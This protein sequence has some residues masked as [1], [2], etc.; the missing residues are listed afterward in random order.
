MVCMCVYAFRY[1]AD[2]SSSMTHWDPKKSWE[3]QKRRRAV[4][5]AAANRMN[6]HGLQA[7]PRL[8]VPSLSSSSSSLSPEEQQRRVRAES[9]EYI[10]CPPP[11]PDAEDAYDDVDLASGDHR[12]AIAELACTK[13]TPPSS[14]G[15]SSKPEGGSASVSS[16]R[17]VISQVEVDRRRKCAIQ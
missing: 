13:S 10:E 17:S 12:G 14:V 9:M 7:Y 5:D 15:S 6:G 16:A 2:I 8:Q 4:S 11:P 3:A 1:D